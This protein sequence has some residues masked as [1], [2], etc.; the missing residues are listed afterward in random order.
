[1]Y[2]LGHVTF[3]LLVGRKLNLSIGFLALGALLPDIVD[4]VLVIFFNIGGGRFIAHTL[5]FAALA[6]CALALLHSKRAGVSLALGSVAHLIEDAYAFVPWF[7]PLLDYEFPVVE[8][9]SIFDHYLGFFG[10]GTDA[11]GLLL[12]IAAYK[13]EI[14]PLNL[15]YLRRWSFF[16]RL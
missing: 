4:K 15:E 3:T 8:S 10:I 11:I 5:A 6:G 9:Y 13:P 12:F 16:R 1:M 2:P 14:L 7:Y